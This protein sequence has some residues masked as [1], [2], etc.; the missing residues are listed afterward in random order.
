MNSQLAI[1]VL[2]VILVILVVGY[3]RLYRHYRRN[4]KK[5]TFLFD[6]IDNGD[7][8]FSFPTEKRFKEDKILHQSL[9]RI[10]LFL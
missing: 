1:I 4:I 10:K 6:A 3:I 7:F 5:V 2:L 8:S 9:N